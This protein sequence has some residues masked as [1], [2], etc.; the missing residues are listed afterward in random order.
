MNRKGQAAM[1]GLI[2]AFVGIIFAL[3]LLGSGGISTSVGQVTTTSN[4]VNQTFT[5]AAVG[6]FVD[7]DACVN[8]AGTPTLINSTG[9][10]IVSDTNYTFTTRVSP[11]NGLKVLTVQTDTGAV[12]ASQGVNASY[13]CLPQGYAEDAGARSITS[14]IVLLSSLALVAFVLFFAWKNLKGI[15]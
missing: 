13:T 7:R 10:E 12:F 5:L 3:A 6:G 2:V 1:G 4:V 14:L 15:V 11:T 8:F 9:G